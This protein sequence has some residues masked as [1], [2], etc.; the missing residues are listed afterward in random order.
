MHCYFGEAER[1]QRRDGALHDRFGGLAV[2]NAGEQHAV[3]EE[4]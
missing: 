3:L 2:T 4:V 1:W